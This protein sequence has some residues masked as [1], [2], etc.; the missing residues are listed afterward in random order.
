M[1]EENKVSEETEE[2]EV[3]EIAQEDAESRK[4]HERLYKIVQF[5]ALFFLLGA[6]FIL[7]AYSKNASETFRIV[8]A[9]VFYA[10]A[11]ILFI[12]YVVF[13]RGLF[14]GDLT[15]EYLSTLGDEEREKT[16]AKEEKRKKRSSAVLAF[17]LPITAIV[18]I[19]A[20]VQLILGNLQK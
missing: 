9:Y 3:E 18:V 20:F 1:E 17:L 2:V 11:V 13:N 8:S 19:D 4:K 5:F 15:E 7:T 12:L 6:I 14:A 10:A 16:L